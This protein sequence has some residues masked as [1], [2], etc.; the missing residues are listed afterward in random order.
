MRRSLIVANWKMN[1]GQA[2]QARALVRR[3]RPYLSR[4]NSI[5]IVIC[6]PFTVL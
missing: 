3:L 6:P 5:E 2:D 4:L 1:L